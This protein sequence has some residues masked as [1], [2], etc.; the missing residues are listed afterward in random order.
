M[1]LYSLCRGHLRCLVQTNKIWAAPSVSGLVQEKKHYSEQSGTRQVD[2]PNALRCRLMPWQRF[3]TDFYSQ[4]VE[5]KSLLWRENLI[6]KGTGIC[7]T[8]NQARQQQLSGVSA[9]LEKG[10]RTL[11]KV[12]SLFFFCSSLQKCPI[13]HIAAE[14]PRFRLVAGTFTWQS[15][16]PVVLRQHML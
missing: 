14:S 6:Q 13:C 1:W 16:G 10:L 7:K 5:S 11:N 12:K 3:K 4:L 8:V 2:L 9:W 15:G